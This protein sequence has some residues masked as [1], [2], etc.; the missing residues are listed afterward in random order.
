MHSFFVF[1][2][3]FAAGCD[4]DSGPEEPR[5]ASYPLKDYVL[6]SRRPWT[7]RPY[8]EL[9]VIRTTEDTAD[10]IVPSDIL[11]E[12]IDFSEYTVLPIQGSTNCRVREITK[13]L[14]CRTK[15]LFSI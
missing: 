5:P 10:C 1:A 6:N 14:R 2:R 3:L 12:D 11:P 8:D 13:K 7:E 9:F 4:D 15:S